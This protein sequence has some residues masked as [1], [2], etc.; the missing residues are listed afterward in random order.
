MVVVHVTTIAWYRTNL[1]PN[2]VRANMLHDISLCHLMRARAHGHKK[3][4]RTLQMTALVP[5][6]VCAPKRDSSFIH[7]C[8]PA[9]TSVRTHTLRHH[10]RAR[11]R[12]STSTASTEYAS[13]IM[14]IHPMC[15]KK[16]T[17]A[18]NRID[19]RVN[20][21]AHDYTRAMQAMG[22][23]SAPSNKH[24]FACQ[25]ERYAHT[26][27]LEQREPSNRGYALRG[28]LQWASV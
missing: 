8:M 11:R 4:A 7:L 3:T 14:H 27:C 16:D 6:C 20:T 9:S 22:N 12:A 21:C 15:K 24:T 28:S 1:P 18:R 26:S 13:T 10:T 17:H 5:S 25:L 23:R 2:L 19:E